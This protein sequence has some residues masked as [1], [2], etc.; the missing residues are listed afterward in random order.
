MDVRF[1]WA[2]KVPPDDQAEGLHEFGLSWY[3]F[4]EEP[5]GLDPS[6]APVPAVWVKFD[7]VEQLEIIQARFPEA[8]LGPASSFTEALIFAENRERAKT[9][10]KNLIALLGSRED[11]AAMEEILREDTMEDY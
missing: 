8:K 4:A 1:I 5:S 7:A 3:R 11:D 9:L 10:Q 6:L 2:E